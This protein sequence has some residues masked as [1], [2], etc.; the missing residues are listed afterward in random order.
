MSDAYGKGI[1]RGQV[2][3]TYLRAYARDHDVAAAEYIKACLTVNWFGA[4]L[5]ICLN[6]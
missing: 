4:V 1:V 5:L 6:A 2:E 3:N